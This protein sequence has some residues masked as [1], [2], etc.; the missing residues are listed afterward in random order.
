MIVGVSL[1]DGEI[2][3][4]RVTGELIRPVVLLEDAEHDISVFFIGSYD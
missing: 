3:R 2:L 4:N 1:N